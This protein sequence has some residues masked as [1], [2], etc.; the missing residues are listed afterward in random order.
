VPDAETRETLASGLR[1]HGVDLAVSERLAAYG[2]Q[3]LEANR[4]VNLTGAN[5]AAALL[6]HL[7]DALTLVPFIEGSGALV[8]VGSGGGLPGIPL[9]IATG[10]RVTLIEPT[11]KKAAFLREALA[12]AGLEGEALAERAEVSA[13]NPRYREQFDYAT[14]RAVSRAPTVA[15]LT[16]PFLRIGGRALL[17]RGA[18]DERESEALLGAAL[19]LGA[20]VREETVLVGDLRVVVLVKVRHIGERFPRRNGVPEK[21]PLCF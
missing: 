6:P 21:R 4:R 18:I 19:M 17:Q 8:D 15:E 9:A 13:R 20:E 11:A 5:D 3:L 14:A 10:V 16:M 2:A 12:Y 1:E 7:L